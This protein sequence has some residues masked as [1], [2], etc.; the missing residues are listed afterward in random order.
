MA[1]NI[2]FPPATSLLSM[3]API[4]YAHDSVEGGGGEG[5]AD[6]AKIVV[7]QLIY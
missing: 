1:F 4:M 7:V 6:V 2:S 5:T 3:E